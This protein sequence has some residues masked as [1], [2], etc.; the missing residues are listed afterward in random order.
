MN[1]ERLAWIAS[2]VVISV[3]ALQLPGSMAQRDDDYKFVRT[4]VDIHRQVTV[5]Y[6]E[7][8]K[9]EE[10]RAAAING[11]LAT[12]DPFTLYVPPEDE[13]AFNQALE[14]SFEGVGIQLDQREN[15]PITV[16]TPIDGSPAAKAGVRAGD[17]IVKVNGEDVSGLKLQ[18]L[19]SKVKGP[20]GTNVTLS[21][22]RGDAANG[23]VVDLTMPRANYTIP[24]VKGYNRKADNSWNYYVLESPKIAYV[25]IAQFTPDTLQSLQP[26]LEGLVK[27]GT[28][29]LVLDLR[30]NPGGLLEQAVDIADLF[31]DSGTI[32][33]TRGRNR[34]ERIEVAHRDG[35]LPNFP[36]AV[37]VNEH[38]ASASEVLAGALADN[39]RAV[40]VGTRSYG[41]GSV[42]E[43]IRLDGKSGELKLTVAYYYLP[44]GRL[45]HRKKDSTAWGVDPSIPVPVDEQTQVAVWESRLASDNWH[46][47]TGVATTVPAPT[48]QI[49]D[50]QL[51]Q[52][53]NTVVALTMMNEKNATTQPSR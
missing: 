34:P 52:A 42:Q 16:V 43:V 25:R 28:Q 19:I 40:V 22:R 26:V 35:T 13:K 44:S 29:G 3:L 20:A 51:Q 18:E 30:F 37:I 15:G 14:G 4:V 45:V 5:N 11:M 9:E 41:K 46:P 2:T 49:V 24:T 1:R 12:L 17:T 27:D 39:R 53:I 6:V 50:T 8:V 23:Q 48:T 7:P 33:T 38:S 31:L 21:L 32:V 36:M 47:P 10:L